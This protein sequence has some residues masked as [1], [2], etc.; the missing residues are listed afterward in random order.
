MKLPKH[1]WFYD[2][3][4]LFNFRMVWPVTTDSL[5]Q[6]IKD[7]FKEDYDARMSGG[8]ALVV[9]NKDGIQT[10]IV[11]LSRWKGTA[12]CHANLVHE[13]N[14]VALMILE[15]RNIE[16]TTSNDECFAYLSAYLARK[17]LNVLLPKRLQ[18][19]VDHKLNPNTRTR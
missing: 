10:Y 2:E 13:C 12:D 3:L 6:Y 11:A 7:E 5:R 17:C 1:Y 14:H 16:V 18:V 4:L 15:R 19:Q 8:K 9:E